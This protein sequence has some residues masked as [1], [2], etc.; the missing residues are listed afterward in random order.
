MLNL[1]KYDMEAMKTK[2]INEPE[3]TS[4]GPTKVLR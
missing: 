1:E 2:L 3:Q 4:Q